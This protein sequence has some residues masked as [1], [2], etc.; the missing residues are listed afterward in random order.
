MRRGEERWEQALGK[1]GLKVTYTTTSWTGVVW[2]IRMTR[3]T[4]TEDGIVPPFPI[5][6]IFRMPS[7]L[8]APLISNARNNDLLTTHFW[9]FVSLQS[10]AMQV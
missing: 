1:G 3:V 9:C 10:W 8:P 2:Y 5:R 6:A 7:H 4:E